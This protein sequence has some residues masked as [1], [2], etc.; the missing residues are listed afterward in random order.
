MQNNI[1]FVILKKTGNT[2]N[3]I[4]FAVIVAV[5]LTFVLPSCQKAP[6]LSITGPTNV[7][8]NAD[9]GSSTLSFISNRDWTIS[10]SDSWIS[11]SPS[12]GTA[13][14][15]SVT[16]SVR[17]NANTTYEDRSGT[18]TIK[19]EDLT[20]TITVR[21][22]ANL[23][24]IVPTKSYEL[25]SS[26]NTIE[27]EVQA[28][29][30]YSVSV[31]DSWIK[32]TGTKALTKNI[33]VFSVSENTT[34]D[35]RS[36]SITITSQSSGVPD[37]VVT[38]R[39]AQ[40]DA[41]I[42]SDSSFSLP[43]G[44]GGVE[45]KVEANIE[46]DVIPNADWIHHVDTKALSG[47]TVSLM[48]DENTTYASREGKVEIKQKN[49]NLTHTV[50]VK[51]AGRVAV[52]SVSL[53][54]SSLNLTEGETATLTATVK[55]DNATDKSVTWSSSDTSVATVDENGN[56]TAVIEGF[57][58]ITA[59][60]GEK[61]ASCPVTVT[62][63][64]LQAVDLGLSVKWGS[65]N[66][67]AKRPE[68]CGE[69]YAWGEVESKTDF[70]WAT[71]KWAN[72]SDNTLTKYCRTNELWD[73]AGSPDNKSRL[74]PEDDAAHVKLGGKWRMP[75]E[76]EWTELEEKC[77]WQW[78]TQ[79]GV[80]GMKVTG[81]SG[82]S[83][84]LVAA[85]FKTSDIHWLGT[86]GYYWSSSI[87]KSV[88]SHNGRC[89]TF[90]YSGDV[91]WCDY[92]RY[93]GLSIRP[94]FAEETPVEAVALSRT[95]YGLTIGE[96][97]TLTAIVKPADATSQTVT[98]DSSDSSIVSVDNGTIKANRYGKATITASCDG[99]SADCIVYV[100]SE[101]DLD[102]E[103]KVTIDLTGNGISV[104]NGGTYYIRYYKIT[105]NSI[106]DIDVYEI[107]TSNF[108][109]LVTT[110]P[111]GSFYDTGLSFN[112]NV[113]PLVTVKF[114]HHEYEYSISGGSQ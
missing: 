94:V 103:S 26:S 82:N 105:N 49:G 85:G 99:V 25:T 72:G 36:A 80:D 73:G 40:N 46:F 11:V 54:K 97:Y 96:E 114:R 60:A 91:D 51:Q 9:G 62:A 74:D 39:Q 47:S 32:Q 87:S 7:E 64:E 10:W 38:V 4:V 43:Y 44:G 77:Q 95:S 90:G 75:T 48:I 27:V 68:D 18:V 106:V 83:I 33:L 42:V 52:T 92:S 21:Q 15:G 29:V 89:E 12:S 88:N 30:L 81:P 70:S 2:M 113:V 23:G 93:A 31:S 104:T 108:I 69:Y 41:L 45:V 55:P 16:V 63:P 20:Q 13:S 98:W 66:L 8:I 53:N 67:G 14:D 112:Y 61:S 22:P 65:F 100:L 1:I 28:N 71:Y 107:G 57:A 58:T 37:Q 110:I 24:L 35:G 50:T 102:L 5:G 76:A 3:R 111:A 84:F 78:T 101:E 109:P 17:C 19:A 59:T 79:N 6:E 86:F 56:V 34:Y